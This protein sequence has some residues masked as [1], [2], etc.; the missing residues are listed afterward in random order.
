MGSNSFHLVVVGVSDEGR[1]TTI[2]RAKEMVRLGESA[3]SE[4]VIPAAAFE[5]G[6]AALARLRD[7]AFRHQ[8]EAILA[9]GTSAL[10]EARNGPA[11]VAAAKLQLGLDIR[12]IEGVE[13]AHLIYEGAR[14]ILPFAD[15]KVALFDLGG[16]STE[17]IV[18]DVDGYLFATS[19]KLGVLRLRT[20]RSSWECSDDEIS[21]ATEARV[22]A[23]AESA[24]ADMKRE[25]FSTVAFSSGTAKTLARLASN[26]GV[27][28]SP[29]GGT[30]LSVAGLRAIE[31]L[32]KGLTI[33]E[34]GRLP[35]LEER[36]ADTILG[37]A[38]ILRTLLEMTGRQQAFV[39]SAALREGMIVDYLARTKAS[40]A[41]GR[42]A[43]RT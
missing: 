20:S 38:I 34:I 9:A 35:G 42:S 2:A 11:F 31:K 32:L 13:E 39:C 26:T 17:A 3:L 16:G 43:P 1:I 6:L 19:L 18:G 7:I 23:V 22:R 28:R 27:E 12:V 40:Q 25:G 36:R 29:D 5:R 21:A 30:W 24:V 37:G 41:P 4:G 15:G 14:Q 33:A 8:P 10:R